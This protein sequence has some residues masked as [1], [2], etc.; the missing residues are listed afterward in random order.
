MILLRHLPLWREFLALDY[1]PRGRWL[2]IGVQD[3][4]P[5]ACKEPGFAFPTL[6]ALLSAR[7]A[8]VS[9]LDL[10]DP[11]ADLRYDLNQPIPAE[12]HQRFDVLLD[13]GSLEHVFDTRQALVNYLELVRV[14]GYLCLHAPVAGFFN[15]GLHTFSPETIREALRL[16]G[17]RLAY[18]R[19]S[20]DSGYP[21]PPQHIGNFDTLQ[22]L[23]AQKTE[24]LGTF[25]N[26]Q[27][28][29][30]QGYAKAN[31]AAAPPPVS[32][33]QAAPATDPRP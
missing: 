26:P 24:P 33:E 6:T 32:S 17:C 21:I 9:T 29:R 18:E 8:A 7:G 13:V 11:R 16:N 19:Y 12:E 25:R 3:I 5:T 28:R 14:G 30:W 23:V 20:L 4:H 31:G 22:W 27:Q 10:F 2:T 1:L 15:H